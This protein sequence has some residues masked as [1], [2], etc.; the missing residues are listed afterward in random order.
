[1]KFKEYVH[2]MP[3]VLS[4]HQNPPSSPHRLTTDKRLDL[5]WPVVPLLLL[6]PV[7]VQKEEM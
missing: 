2:A 7:L 6:F 5:I 4:L 1:M 3:S